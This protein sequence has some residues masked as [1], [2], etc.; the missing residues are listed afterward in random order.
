MVLSGSFVRAVPFTAG[1]TIVA[2]FDHFGEVTLMVGPMSERS[3]RTNVTVHFAR[4]CTPSSEVRHP[5]MVH[6]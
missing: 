4:W 5:V 2:I 3:E 1:D 6:Q